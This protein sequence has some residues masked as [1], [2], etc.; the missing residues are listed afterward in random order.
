MAAV[1]FTMISGAIIYEIDGAEALRSHVHLL[2][3]IGAVAEL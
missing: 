1:G 3:Q 2:Q